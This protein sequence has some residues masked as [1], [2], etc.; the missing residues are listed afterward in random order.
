VLAD[1]AIIVALVAAVL[2]G[3][4]RGALRQFLCLGAWL[5]AFLFAVYL[6]PPIVDWLIGQEPD[7]SR[8]Y[9]NMVAFVAAYAVLF[10]LA[11]LVI[12]IGGRTVQLTSR[13]LVDEMVGGVTML[14]VGVLAIAGLQI[15]L[16]S[17]F[18]LPDNEPTAEVEQLRALNVEL[19]RSTI[20]NALRDTLEPG[21]KTLLGPLLPADVHGP[22]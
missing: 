3:V 1:V 17:W 10:T 14:L 6:R 13:P 9:A 7:F 22:G 21:I 15:A 4:F 8:S 11:V 16:D 2:L 12:E 19:Q 18:T 20:A 5:V